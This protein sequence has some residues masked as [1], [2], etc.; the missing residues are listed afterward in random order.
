MVHVVVFDHFR[1]F[2]PNLVESCMGWKSII[3]SK[4][5]EFYI[6][7]IGS[8]WSFVLCMIR[9]GL[10]WKIKSGQNTTNY[11]PIFSIVE[12]FLIGGSVIVAF[13]HSFSRL[14][15]LWKRNFRNKRMV[16]SITDNTHQIQNTTRVLKLFYVV[17]IHL[18]INIRESYSIKLWFAFPLF[19]IVK[20][21]NLL[22]VLVEN[23]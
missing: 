20:N 1:F 17:G 21:M 19:C 23:L 13:H 2:R 7:M 12:T 22:F 14:C 6:K 10:A 16:T 8:S 9:P 15:I 18:I 5:L 3:H 11:T 4:Y